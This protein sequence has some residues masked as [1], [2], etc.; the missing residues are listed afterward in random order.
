MF[1]TN[2]A[3]RVFRHAI[4]LDEHRV[5]FVPNFYHNDNKFDSDEPQMMHETRRQSTSAHLEAEEINRSTGQVTDSKE[6]ELSCCP[7]YWRA[8]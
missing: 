4:A 1:S 5:R 8:Y 6:G 3:I 2:T 7:Q